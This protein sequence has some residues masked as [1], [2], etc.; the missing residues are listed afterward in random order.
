[1]TWKHGSTLRRL[2]NALKTFDAEPR[3]INFTDGMYPLL[4]RLYEMAEST[5][6]HFWNDRLF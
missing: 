2:L 6:P 3:R 1:M 5:T 4:I